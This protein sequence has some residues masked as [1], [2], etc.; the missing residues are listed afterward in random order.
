[1]KDEY[2][3]NRLI[4]ENS[5]IA[6]SRPTVTNISKWISEYIDSPHTVLDYGATD[7]ERTPFSDSAQVSITDIQKPY[8]T[9]DAFDLL[10]CLHVL[11]HVSSI[12]DTI[13]DILKY[14]FKYAYFEVPNESHMQKY[15]TLEDRVHNKQFWHEHQ[16][17]FTVNSFKT[18]IPS[19]LELITENVTEQV[20]QV[21]YRVKG[22]TV[23]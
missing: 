6:K 14:K 9:D 8:C 3:N 21:L 22:I 13:R 4:F 5:V 11:E 16:N 18:I 2:M 1:M 15:T 12:H 19:S 7:S 20:I 23:M 17:F 10:T